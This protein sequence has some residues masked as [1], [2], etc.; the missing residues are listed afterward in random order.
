MYLNLVK[1]D[2]KI[3]DNNNLKMLGKH[4]RGGGVNCDDRLIFFSIKHWSIP[5]SYDK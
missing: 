4:K 2:C 5:F 3:F 1:L